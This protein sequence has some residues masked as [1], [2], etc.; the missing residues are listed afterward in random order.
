MSSLENLRQIISKLTP[1]ERSVASDFLQLFNTRGENNQTKFLKMFELLC[2]EIEENE[3]LTESQIE[4]HLYGK[5]ST[6]AFPKLILRLKS[7]II[8]S[9]TL[10]INLERKEIYTDRGRSVHYIRKQLSAAQILSFRGLN[11]LSSDILD[12]CITYASKYEFYEEWLTALRINMQHNALHNKSLKSQKQATEFDRV[13]KM[14]NAAKLAQGYYADIINHLEYHS[15]PMDTNILRFRSNELKKIASETKSSN[16]AYFQTFL[17]IQLYQELGQYV[18][19]TEILLKQ[20]RL[21]DKFPA[22]QSKERLSLSYINLGWNELLTHRFRNTIRYTKKVNDLLPV[23]HVNRNQNNLNQFYAFYYIGDYD[24]ALKMLDLIDETDTGFDAEF[25]I[26]K[27]LYLRAC[28][29][30]LKSEYKQVNE[31]LRDLN[32]I[33]KDIEGWNIWFRILHIQNDIEMELIENAFNRIQGLRKQ[34]IKLK[35]TSG[36]TARINLIYEILKC[37]ANCRF[38]FNEVRK[39]AQL[40]L[41]ALTQEIKSRWRILSPELVVFDQWFESHYYR[42]KF[43]QVIPEYWE[44]AQ[45]A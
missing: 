38:E 32:P 3:R 35:S 12:E 23:N 43:K 25:R 15:E 27:R 30:F 21:I 19:A 22:L 34:I 26:G 39:K 20:I 28:V 45:T 41:N 36:D 17:E 10:N 6:M 14:L 44:P 9:L 2:A 31:I 1:E 24:K 29:L 16:V 11:K 5:V 37:L 33:E 7:K 4:E 42:T 40:E 8:E 13:L 18:N